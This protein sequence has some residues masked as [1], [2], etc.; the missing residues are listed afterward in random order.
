LH[1]KGGKRHALPP[2]L[3]TYL[4]AYIDDCKL[5]SDPKGPLFRTIGRGTRKLTATTLPQANAYAMVP[6][7]AGGAD[8]ATKQ[9]VSRHTLRTAARSK[10]PPSWRTTPQ[11]GTTRLYDRRHDDVRLDEVER[12]QSDFRT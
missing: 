4:H 6:R 12:I 8:I 7:R 11:H 3:E 1:E 5:D 10:E 9:R 2:N